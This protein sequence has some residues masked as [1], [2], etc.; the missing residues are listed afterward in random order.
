MDDDLLTKQF[1]AFVDEVV[2]APMRLAESLETGA[3]EAARALSER[4]QRLME[5]QDAHIE[6]EV[7]RF[8]IDNVADARY[9]KAAL[10]DEILLTRPWAG[11]ESWTRHLLESAVFQTHVAGE[12]VFERIDRLLADRDP[13]RRR[14]ARLY[15]FALAMG[16][17][18]RYRGG[19]DLARL[20]SY[21]LALFQF[22]YRRP[23]DPGGQGRVLDEAPYKQTLSHLAPRRNAALSRWW[24][25]AA[26]AAAGLL[27]ASEI[28]WLSTTW[29]IR[30]GLRSVGEGT[31]V[32]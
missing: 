21:R 31:V 15:L 7:T 9:L 10:A 1:S 25:G 23:P 14:L 30:E 5:F 18:G 3:D 11:R 28:L 32:R 22:A 26:L 4:L 8:E 24:V 20:E 2:N 29:P 27:V 17:E 19:A 16:F 6:R 13:S 12:A